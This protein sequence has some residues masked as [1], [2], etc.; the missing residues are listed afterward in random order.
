M[1]AYHLSV[2][3]LSLLGLVVAVSGQEPTTTTSSFCKTEFSEIA[4]GTTETITEPRYTVYVTD[5]TTTI[6]P[7]TIYVDSSET[8]YTIAS[9]PFT[10]ETAADAIM[11]T[12][13]TIKFNRT[14]CTNNPSFPLVTATVFSGSYALI[15]GQTV[16]VQCTVTTTL[17]YLAYPTTVTRD[18]TVTST[19]TDG[20]IKTMTLRGTHTSTIYPI[21]V[22]PYISN[23][24]FARSTFTTTKSYQAIETVIFHTRY[25]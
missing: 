10:L 15:P 19:I 21:T 23:W 18:L 12:I 9:T 4:T 6:S 13:A 5:G 17:T 7:T 22:T 11:T 14:A 20:V 24:V 16:T 8:I 1:T 25:E 2:L 3:S